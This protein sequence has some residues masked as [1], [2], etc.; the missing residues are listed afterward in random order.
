M[1][2][3]VAMVAGLAP[4]SWAWTEMVGKST[5]GSGETGRFKKAAIPASAT[6]MVSRMV[7]IGRRTKGAERFIAPAR[8]G[9]GLDRPG[10]AS[11]FRRFGCGR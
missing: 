7:P 3:L 4:A 2:T 6:P 8:L 1:A 10:S 11:P 5:C 9:L